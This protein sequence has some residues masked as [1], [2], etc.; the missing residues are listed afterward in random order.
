MGSQLGTSKG[1]GWIGTVVSI[2]QNIVHHNKVFNI[3]FCRLRER[4]S[5]VGSRGQWGSDRPPRGLRSPKEQGNGSLKPH[6]QPFPYFNFSFFRCIVNHFQERI[7]K[8]HLKVKYALIK[9]TI[10]INRGT[11]IRP[12]LHT[13]SDECNIIT[14]V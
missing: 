10:D 14:K 11:T 8:R 3:F 7:H 6:S 2:C 5:N 13:H 1:D 9:D 12:K 4:Y